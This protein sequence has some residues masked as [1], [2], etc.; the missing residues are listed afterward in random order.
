MSRK[1]RLFIA[2]GLPSDIHRNLSAAQDAL[3]PFARDA[4]WVRTEGIHLTLK[5]L[6]YV[7]EERIPIICESMIPVR[8]SFSAFPIRIRG[9]GFFPNPRR[10]TVL[11][12]GVVSEELPRLQLQVEEAAASLGFEKEKRSFTPHLTLSRFRDPRGLIPLVNETEKWKEADLGNF[13][14]ESFALYES[15]LHRKGAEYIRLK[16]FVFEEN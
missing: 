7:D 10:P 2:I 5:F 9:C 16:S 11:W 12:A 13:V 15:I 3:K 4:K 14:A 6:G 1:K 8:N